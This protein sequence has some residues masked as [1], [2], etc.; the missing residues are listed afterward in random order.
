MTY[1]PRNPATPE[2]QLSAA[3]LAKLAEQ[4]GVAQAL[5]PHGLPRQAERLG[6]LRVVLPGGQQFDGV[7]LR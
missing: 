4:A 1:D 3:A 5:A 7:R 6:S 2:G